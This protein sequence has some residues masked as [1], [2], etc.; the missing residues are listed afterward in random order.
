ML[1]FHIQKGSAAG[2]NLVRSLRLLKRLDFTAQKADCQQ[3]ER[4]NVGHQTKQF[5]NRRHSKTYPPATRQLIE[6]PTDS[7]ECLRAVCDVCREIR[8]NLA[9]IEFNEVSSFN[10]N[11]VTHFEAF[12]VDRLPYWPLQTFA[13]FS[14]CVFECELPRFLS[15]SLAEQLYR[16]ASVLFQEAS[17]ESAFRIRF[18]VHIATTQAARKACLGLDSK[19]WRPLKRGLDANRTKSMGL[20]ICDH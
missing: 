19:L 17:S 10:D 3:V 15:V 2:V 6:Q 5:N 14:V 18:N 12:G 9:L 16:T 11:K 4:R 7:V 20:L 13:N 8:V 1:K